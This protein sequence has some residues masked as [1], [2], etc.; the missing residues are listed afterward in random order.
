MVSTDLHLAAI[1]RMSVAIT[2]IHVTYITTVLSAASQV[3]LSQK[4]LHIRGSDGAT[5]QQ[6]T[7]N[8]TGAG[9]GM[10]TEIRER[11]MGREWEWE[12]VPVGAT[13]M[14]TRDGQTGC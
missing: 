13:C 8:G 6:G 2:Y 14:R 5:E 4:P 9:T 11:E 1:F 7:G 10:G 3:R 12:T